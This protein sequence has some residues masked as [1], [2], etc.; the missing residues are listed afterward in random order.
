METIP[1]P[2]PSPQED[3]SGSMRRKIQY[4]GEIIYHC[5]LALA[6]LRHRSAQGAHPRSQGD[7]IAMRAAHASITGKSMWTM[8]TYIASAGIRFGSNI[9]LS[10]LLGPEILGIVVIAQAIR[11]GSELLTDLGLEQNV[12][13]S[14]HGAQRD[15]LNTVWTM[16]ILR[17]LLASLACVALSPLLGDF[18]RIDASLLYVVSATPLL[19][20]LMSTSIF[21]L[22]K[23][24]DV[25][26]RNLF[27][28][29]S[30]LGGLAI[31]ILLAV[32]LRNVWAPIL[33]IPLSIGLRSAL[34]YMLPHPRHQLLLSKTHAPD[35]FHFSK[36]IMLSS[37]ALYAAIYVDRLF[38]GRAVPLAT[39]GV[40]GLAKAIADLPGTVAGRL[41]FQIVFPFV[42]AQEGG[43]PQG[44]PARRELDRA[45][46]NFLLLG[47]LGIGTVMAWSDWAVILLYGKRYAAA[48]WM[49]SLLLWGA[50]IAILSS[51]NEATIF[52]RGRPQNV[53]LANLVRFGVMALLLP[54]GFA[55]KGLPGALLALPASEAVR[56]AILARTQR[57]LE[58]SFLGQDTLLTIGLALVFAFWLATRSVLHLGYPWPQ[59]P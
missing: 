33:A 9:I 19:N 2:A 48:G 53:G 31:T 7:V 4:P 32:T 36:W 46:R 34:S 38:L 50:W 5:R 40:Y 41:A 1:S 23:Q 30:E 11:T 56:Y 15:F 27:E 3:Q 45:R 10:R 22:A 52:G 44:S 58:T 18:Y 6:L 20:A 29:C 59:V 17:G 28:L 16:Q 57:R 49:L 24:M 21:S 14:P 42:A 54:A 25:K 51:L 37:L 39:L 26:T 43:I 13:H 47:L 12:V 8:G 35:I 55:L